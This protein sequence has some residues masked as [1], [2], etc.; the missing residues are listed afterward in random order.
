MAFGSDSGDVAA[1]L[2]DLEKR[3]CRIERHLELRSG[4][5]TEDEVSPEVW[6]LA[7]AGKTLEAIKLHVHET[8][9]DLKYA[10][11]MVEAIQ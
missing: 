8:G 4:S 1:R 6:Q 3:L 9:A 2:D 11:Q 7:Q 5:T 10:K